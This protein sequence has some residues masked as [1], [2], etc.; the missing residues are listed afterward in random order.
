MSDEYESSMFTN[1]FGPLPM[2]TGVKLCSVADHV[3]GDHPHE[4]RLLVGGH[5]GYVAAGAKVVVVCVAVPDGLLVPEEDEH[6]GR[7][8]V[9]VF[10]VPGEFEDRGRTRPVVVAARGGPVAVHV[11]PYHYSQL[12]GAG[13]DRDDVVGSAP[14]GTGTDS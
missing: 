1:V 4:V 12:G 13:L 10:D 9:H 14:V 5:L 8:K 6:H 7:G 2:K 11:R 3:Q